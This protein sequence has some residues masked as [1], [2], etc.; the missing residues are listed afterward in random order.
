MARHFFHTKVEGET[1][2]HDHEGAESPDFEA[3][4][5][6]SEHSVGE[7]LAETLGTLA[8]C[9][10]A[11]SSSVTRAGSSFSRSV[12][13]SIWRSMRNSP[14]T[15]PAPIRNASTYQPIKVKKLWPLLALSDV[16]YLL[17]SPTGPLACAAAW[18]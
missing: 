18:R 8:R 16:C 1:I 15:T 9:A 7:L 5:Q 14:Q 11:P 17:G 10:G 4:R 3:A 13:R 12:P 2:L 6:E